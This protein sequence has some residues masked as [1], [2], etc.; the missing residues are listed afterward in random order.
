[1]RSAFPDW[2]TPALLVLLLGCRD[3]GTP[4][5]SDA[6]PSPADE[7]ALVTGDT[8]VDGAA[9]DGRGVDLAPDRPEE[10]D[11]EDAPAF[12]ATM[13]AD[14][15]PSEDVAGGADNF[16]PGDDGAAPDEVPAS[17]SD[18]GGQE[19]DAP[20]APDAPPADSGPPPFPSCPTFAAGQLSG[21]VLH[22]SVN[23]ASGVVASRKNAGVLWMHNDSGGKAEIY[24]VATNGTHRGTYALEGTEAKD[25]EDIAIGPGPTGGTQYIYVADVG[26]NGSSRTDYRL[27]RVP[28]PVADGGLIGAV[29]LTGVEEIEIDYPDGS[30]NAEAMF[31]DPWTADVYIVT[32]RGNGETP[33]Y[34]AAAPLKTNGSNVMAHVI[35]L[36]FGTGALPG[37]TEATA[38]DMSP[39][40]DAIAIRTYQ[41]AFLWRRTSGMTV[42]EALATEPCP[43]PVTD[44][45]M[46][47]ALGF[48]S[49]G[50]G[51]YTVPEGKVV[52][53]YHFPRR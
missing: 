38:A 41:S 51:Y 19:E 26:D 43:I 24:G 31:V 48:A 4:P 47:E 40:G 32:K 17:D 27:Y 7:G 52:G 28:E 36:Q 14:P 21:W 22:A 1:M 25:W 13:P 11:G 20:V 10:P 53:I 3:P 35:T 29:P 34:R 8:E 30:H 33:V 46:G 49:D 9:A 18:E 42:A 2:R 15:T 37:G 50:K 39:A 23:E 6:L 16:L 5:A 12:D 45:S 44:Q